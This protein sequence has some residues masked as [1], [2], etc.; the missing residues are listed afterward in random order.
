MDTPHDFSLYFK[1]DYQE[2]AIFQ[3]WFCIYRSLRY[4]IHKK[5]YNHVKTYVFYFSLLSWPLK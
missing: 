1:L 2:D 5:G 4:P 3:K